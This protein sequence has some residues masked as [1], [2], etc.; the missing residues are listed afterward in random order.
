M[1]KNK[2]LDNNIS[3]FNVA[4]VIVDFIFI[5]FFVNLSFYDD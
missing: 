1:V 2:E 4:D 3:D 5:R